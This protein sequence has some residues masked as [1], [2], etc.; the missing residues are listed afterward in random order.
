VLSA[1]LAQL[2][3]DQRAVFVMHEMEGWSMPEV[4]GALSIPLNTGYSRLRL[5]REQVKEAVTRLRAQ[6]GDHG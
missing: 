3:L 5:A 6:G 4:A 2:G 1:A